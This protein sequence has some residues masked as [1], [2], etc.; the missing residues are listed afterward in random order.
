MRKL[1][2]LASLLFITLA[3]SAQT[4]IEGIAIDVIEGDIILV[5]SNE[6]D[7]LAVKFRNIECPELK[8]DFGDKAKAYTQ[9]ICLKERITISY[10]D[11]DRDRNILG[12]VVL[13]NGKDVGLELLNEGLAW[14]YMKGLDLGPHSASYIEQEKTAREKKRGL[15]KEKDPMAPWTF[16][17]HQN[18]WLGKTSI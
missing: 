3:G 17:N 4:I 1:T 6:G 16:R 13:K 11:Y 14:H 10:D 12:T 9:K 18:K 8:Q 15:W 5:L 2:I 7:T